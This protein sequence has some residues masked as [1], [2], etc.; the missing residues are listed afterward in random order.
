MRSPLVV[1]ALVA[2]VATTACQK[3]AQP[4]PPTKSETLAELRVVRRG[5]HVTEEGKAE[6][7]P[8]PRERLTASEVVK[9]DDGALAWLRRDGGSTLLVKG[10]AKLT[11][12][13]D[14]VDVTEGSIFAESP[15]GI[16][17][18][19][20]TPQGGLAL[21]DVR[22]SVEVSA[23]RSRVYVLTGEVRATGDK[24]ARAGEALTLA[25]EGTTVAPEAAWD[26]WTG[27]LA[28]TD[29]TA[30][31]APFGI[32]TVGARAAG[33]SGAPRAPLTIQRLD[34]RVDVVG[35][36]ATTE[37]DETFFN[38][39]SSTVEGIY[40]FR[41]PEGANLQRFGVDRLGGIAWGY[42]KE[43][44]AASAQYASNV[45]QGSTEDPA[46]LEWKAPGEYEAR[47]YPIDAG[48]TRR[49]V[50][51][52][53]EWLGRSGAG[54][55]RR[56]YT[57]PM[58]AEGSEAS[59]PHIEELNAVV[60]LSKASAGAVRA[61][62]DATREG[63]V[64][65]V[66]RHD[67][68]PR[69]DLSVEMF[70][71][72]D[73]G[74][75]DPSKTFRKPG[76]TRIYQAGHALD[77]AMLPPDQ[78]AS[79]TNAK[80]PE[81]GYVL[82]PV[83]IADLPK[84]SGG[85]DLEIIVDTSAATD[86]SSLSLERA[87]VKSLMA[88]LGKGDRVAVMTGDDELRPVL[89]VKDAKASA[90]RAADD[91]T[92]ADILDGLSRVRQGGATDLGRMFDDAI[93]K[94]PEDRAS[95][96]VYIGDGTPTVGE[97]SLADLR[98][99]LAKAPHPARIFALGVGEGANMGLLAGVAAGGF[100]EP[101]ADEHAAALS[102][103]HVLEVAERSADLGVT[104]D[105]GPNVE[106]VYPRDTSAITEG[107]T[108]LVVG[109]QTG[110][111][112]PTELVVKGS[113]GEKTLSLVATKIDDG[114][115]LR[116]RWATGRL[117]Q[118]MTES[119]GPAALADLGVRQG[120]ITPVT[121]IYVPTT[122]EMT[123]AQ[124]EAIETEKQARVTSRA[125]PARSGET[126]G[127]AKHADR[128]DDEGKNHRPRLEDQRNQATPRMASK[129]AGSTR[130]STPT[131]AADPAM[132]EATAAATATAQAGPPPPGADAQAARGKSRDGFMKDNANNGDVGA[133]DPSGGTGMR[134][135]GEEGTVGQPTDAP[136]PAGIEPMPEPSMPAPG[137]AP[138]M[139]FAPK[140]KMGA[141]D[142]N[143][144]SVAR[145]GAGADAKSATATKP[146]D[147]NEQGVK[148]GDGHEKKK[149]VATNITINVPPPVVIV[150]LDN[151]GRWTSQCGDAAR[152][153][154][155]ERVALWRERL[156][157]SGGSPAGARAIYQAALWNCELPTARERTTLLLLMLDFIP[158]T[159]HRVEL[160][161]LMAED[162]GAADILYRGIL[163]RTTTPAAMRELSQA[164]GL[165]TIE[166]SVL[167]K[168]LKD[169]KDP[170]E[171]IAKLRAFV[172][173]FP[174]D[175]GLALTLLDNLEDASDAAGARGFA[176]TLR[177]RPDADA[178]VRTAVGELYLRLADRDADADEK[179]AD[180]EEARR[181]FG[182]IVEFSPD[183]PVARRR[184]GDL[185]RAHGFYED[186]TRQYET[187]AK[188]TP[189]DP[190]VALLLAL[191]CADGLG[192]LEEAVKW[193]EKGGSAGSP[194]AA[195]GPFVTAR[196]FAATYIA[197]GKVDAKQAGDTKTVDA[198]TARLAR[199]LSSAG[200]P[201]AK[202]QVRVVATWS[203]PELHPSLW[204]NALG[205][206]MPAPE[207]DVTLG[208]AQVMMTDRG[209]N[210]VEVR[211]DPEDVDRAAR[212]GAKVR[213]TA[214][215]HE[216]EKDEAIATIDV[217]FA[218]GGP[219]V[220]KV[221]VEGGKLTVESGK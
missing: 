50:V 217:G 136:T 213:I 71:A 186:A 182:E 134:A 195:Q 146:D 200:T 76:E 157:A 181:S 133:M 201:P 198:L 11:V 125:E 79:D 1:V 28:T 196:A 214:V 64:L 177:T 191:A 151:P 160:Y 57:Y 206:P 13:S 203:H 99:R 212:L 149:I 37:V 6:R 96:I 85:L 91:G 52:Y 197:W 202:K 44:K 56:L 120:I 141:V 69:A 215:F 135:K 126:R 65:T 175:L 176:E 67:F 111:K 66:R 207:G 14:A 2:L 143:D 127:L 144:K 140:V 21:S 122:R 168:T 115:D 23:A 47:L 46:L 75:K 119:A 153:P 152:L 190:S 112:V 97:L 17:T 184:L 22:A 12:T 105:F 5:V 68:V 131:T 116:R 163:A 137:P 170:V 130:A 204:S 62:M 104:F 185:F 32:G 221:D 51:R 39:I 220:V 155:P 159:F 26:D 164:L 95:A 113:A 121:S 129:G 94:L 60:D 74:S 25:K 34:V 77:A 118:L 162:M 180:A 148:A 61:G 208:V 205:A 38:P 15:E 88:H 193:T 158:Q 63:D 100:A 183:D 199:V 138:H 109:R 31:P 53:T 84:P 54:G 86:T 166:P 192:K 142:E 70:D 33:A 8:Y 174:N 92:K 98:A 154:F 4:K 48:A 30:E 27:G 169:A 117:D 156:Q 89:A 7:D 139:A 42:V 106:R 124:R 101:V 161:R 189:D 123:A 150:V 43:K 194:D 172:A 218:R 188:L 210:V 110:D 36:L 216:N 10:P 145:F 20:T 45:Y 219:N 171:R 19:V 108:I 147:A 29:R 78:G 49:V 132:A 107:D 102:A 18:D 165:V 24:V 72:I 87:A 187:L 209:G 81:A 179:A 178:R 90:F 3:P 211:V 93:A 40:R 80:N 41:V 114:G 103:L 35:D 167:E 173:Q 58:A 82:V 9:V 83:S 55:E 73:D 59:L 16:V 128:D